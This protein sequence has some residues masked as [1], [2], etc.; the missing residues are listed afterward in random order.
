MS[1]HEV[2]A[3]LWAERE[4]LDVLV[5]KLETEQLL[6]TAGKTR[7]LP[8]ATGEI[9]K[10][11]SKLSEVNLALAVEVSIVAAE[12][13]LPE[14]SSLLQLADSDAAEDVWREILVSHHKALTSSLTELAGLRDSNEHLIRSAIRSTQETLADANGSAA[15]YNASGATHSGRATARLIDK[16]L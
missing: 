6:L 5:F 2:S 11:Q 3:L 1:M 4:L 7:W 15:V 10:I 12:W 9:E 16:E 14:D 8:R 13:D